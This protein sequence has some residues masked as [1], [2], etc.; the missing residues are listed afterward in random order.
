MRR[1]DLLAAVGAAA[2]AGLA[3]CAGYWNEAEAS[4]S[5]W[6]TDTGPGPVVRQSIRFHEPRRRRAVHRARVAWDAAATAVHVTGLMQYGSS[7][8][9]RPGIAET[10]YDADADRLFVRLAPTEREGV[11]RCRADLATDTYRAT[12]SFERSLPASVRVESAKTYQG[13]RLS[14][15]TTVERT[16]SRAEQRELCTTD[17]PDGSAAA[18]RAHWTC[19]E[20][21]VRAAE[22][23]PEE[24]PTA[25]P[26]E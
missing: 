3:G 6:V 21:Y 10:R 13:R 8:C 9:D 20:R 17:H 2:G 12:F 19:P 11:E 4:T 26:E 23:Y 7:S 1:R 5:P 16:V 18:E 22:S 25:M 24:T 14:E 15:P